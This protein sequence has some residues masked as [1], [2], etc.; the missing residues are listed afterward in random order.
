MGFLDF[1]PVVGKAVEGIGNVVSTAMTNKSNKEIMREQNQFNLEQWNR[2]ADFTREMWNA[3][4]EY[5]DPKNQMQRLTDAGLSPWAAAQVLGAGDAS[6]VATPSTSAAQSATMQSPDFGFLGAASQKVLEN[7][8]ATRK[9]AAE[10][11][12]AEAN[13]DAA[14]APRT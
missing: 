14:P 1:I 12:E 2:E 8:M 4:N 3:N 9:K 6:A 5:N 11:K 7:Y 10:V 13:A